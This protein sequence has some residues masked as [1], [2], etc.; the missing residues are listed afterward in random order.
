MAPHKVIVFGPTGAVGSSAARTAHAL[1]AHVVLAMRDTSKSIPGLSS[2]EESSGN[3]SRYTADLTDAASV[4]AVVQKT[5]S[6][7]AFIYH[8]EPDSDGMLST[9]T[10]L[11]KGGIELVVFLS[12][13][14]IQGPIREVP[15]KDAIPWVHARVEVNLENVFGQGNYVAVRPGSFASNNLQYLEGIKKGEVSVWKPDATVDCITPEDIGQVAGT[16]LVKGVP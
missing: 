9:I 16:V 8:T 6:K 12:S 10:A 3:Y 5:D 14:S 1:G 7:H 2:S 11:Q 4:S 13:F 15:E